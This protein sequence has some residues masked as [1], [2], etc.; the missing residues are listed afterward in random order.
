MS[1]ISTE[2]INYIEQSSYALLITVGEESRPFVREIGPFVNSGLDIYFVTRI[3]SQKVKQ[4]AI[5]PYCTL[6]FPNMNPNPKEFRSVAI[7]GM[8]SRIPA[9]AE[10]NDVLEKLDRKSPG[11]S[12][13]ISK[14]GFK[15]WTIFKMATKELQFTDYSKSTRTAK[16]VV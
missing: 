14:E 15:I 2:A 12:N 9:G 4:F 8:V 5:H 7:S 13:Y 6:Y 11:Y 10:F 3:D 16:I 1:S